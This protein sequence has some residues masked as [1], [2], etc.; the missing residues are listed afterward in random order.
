MDGSWLLFVHYRKRLVQTLGTWI[1][2]NNEKFNWKIMWDP[3]AV[4]LYTLWYGWYVNAGDI[5]Y[6]RLNKISSGNSMVSCNG[7]RPI[8]SLNTN[9]CTVST[10]F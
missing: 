8:I 1:A 5:S 10:S 7:A 3:S 6:G 9:R 4:L 2:S